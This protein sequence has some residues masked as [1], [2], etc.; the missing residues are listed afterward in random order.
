M[1]NACIKVSDGHLKEYAEE[2]YL[3]SIATEAAERQRIETGKE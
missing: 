2:K 1:T 3:E